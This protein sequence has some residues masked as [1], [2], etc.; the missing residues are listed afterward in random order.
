MGQG[1][2]RN[3]PVV[4]TLGKDNYCAL[5]ERHGQ[6]TRWR[7][8]SKCSCVN[9]SSMQPDIRCKICSG[10]GIIYSY[11]E[12][13][14]VFEVVKY[15]NNNGI[16]EVSERL[17]NC[18]L[19]EVYNNKGIRQNARKL[20][21]YIYL[22]ENIERNTYYTV[23]CRL[24]NYKILDKAIAINKSNGYFYLDELVNVKGNID[25]LYQSALSDIVEI[26]K[27]TDSNGNEYKAT[28]Y[29]LNSFRIEPLIEEVENEE[30][31][32]IEVKEIPIAEPIIVENVKYIP[33]FIFAILNQNLNESDVNAIAEYQ[34]DAICLFPYECD[35]SE[36]DV[37]TVLIG[38]ITKK[39][40]IVRSAIETDTLGD[41]FVSDIVE[42]TGIINNERYLYQEGIDY[43]LTETNKI[44]WLENAN[45][46]PEEGEAF[47]VTYH[48]L[49]TYKV[50]KNIPQLRTS[51]NQ[52]F[53]KKVV[54]KLHSTYSENVGVNKQVVG[55]KG[56]QGSY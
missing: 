5:I 56:V 17:E 18:N 33:P 27:I 24:P 12:D 32:E 42:C 16:L 14:I 52:R 44:K 49:P 11:Q 19:V 2:G 9:S 51:E 30:T 54:V 7:T 50:V 53:P 46:Y 55:R 6:W 47:S 41:F 36:D 45:A 3:S 21:K 23:I 22:N 28:E 35:V 1:L 10:R 8:A 29:R 26:G 31:G 43:I 40:V 25:G 39:E 34:G 4:L 20:G 13:Q 48:V 38:S 37:L 15:S